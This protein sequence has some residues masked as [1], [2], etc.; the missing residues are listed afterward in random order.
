MEFDENGNQ[1][2]YVLLEMAGEQAYIPEYEVTKD[3]DGDYYATVI[4]KPG[5]GQRIMVRKN[6]NDNS[7]IAHGAGV[8]HGL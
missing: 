7:D 4:N 3:Q 2:E 5:S 8:P 6:W 1:Y